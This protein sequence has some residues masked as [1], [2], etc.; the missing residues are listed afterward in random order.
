MKNNVLIILSFFIFV[1]FYS[2]V[3]N[4]GIAHVDTEYILEKIP[5]YQDAQKELEEL[6]KEYRKVVDAKYRE[7]DSLYNNYQK[8][9][10]LLPDQTK[11]KK[12]NEIIE[13]EQ[14][15]KEL[16]EKY[17]GREGELH[18]KREELIKPIQD[19][20]YEALVEIAEAGNYEYIFDNVTGEILYAAEKNNEGDAVL[21]KLGY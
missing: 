2:P 19:N 10:P 1:S 17:F 14:I 16:Q 18:Q 3:S 9:E 12:Q 15:A 5:A 6:A 11:V 20:I 7:V 13:K 4:S 21:K 8:E